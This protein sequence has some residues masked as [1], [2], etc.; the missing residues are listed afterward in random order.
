MKDN[1]IRRNLY[2]ALRKIGVP[3]QYITEKAG[4]QGELLIDNV[5]MQCFLFYVESI[6]GLRIY[7]DDI[8]HFATVGSTIEYLQQRCK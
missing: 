3:R 7:N 4:L 5:D 6:F 1:S 8:S 2:R